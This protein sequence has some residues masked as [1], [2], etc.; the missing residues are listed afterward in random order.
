MDNKKL[1]LRKGCTIAVLVYIL[2]AA[3][4]LFI[5]RYQIKYTRDEAVTMAENATT[6]LGALQD[7]DVVTQHVKNG[8]QFLSS[9]Q[10]YFA[11]YGQKNQGQVTM[12]TTD[13][14]T[15]A[16]IF[17]KT[18]AL[19]GFADNAWHTFAADD[20]IDVSDSMDHEFE[21]TFTFALSEGDS[22]TMGCGNDL[23]G[24]RI[25]LLNG[26]QMVGN[27]CVTLN[28][29]NLSGKAFLYPVMLGVL[30]VLLIAGSI[31]IVSCDARDKK[32]VIVDFFYLCRRY[33]FLMDQLV[34]RD[35]KTKYKRSVL[36]VF[37]SFLNPLLTM[38]VQYVVF[39][40]LFR[41]NVPNYPMYLLTGIVF[42]NG[43]NDASTQAMNAIVGNASLIT[44]VYVPKYIYP[45]SKVLSA[46]INILFSLIPLF[47][48]ALI[49]GV[50]PSL[51]LLLIP[52][53]V[54]CYLLFIIGLSFILSSAMTFFRDMQF[55]WGVFTMMWMYAT[56]VIYP[57]STIEG[58]FLHPLQKI[59]PLYHFITFFR[60]VI[61]SGVSP[62]PT[63]YIICIGIAVIA[64]AVG[65]FVFRK[66]QDKFILYI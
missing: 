41:F 17:E 13:L 54:V 51:S 23:T 1:N 55:L 34:S 24:D 16:V 42:F 40:R 10:A 63:E 66:S 20:L 48:V 46:S 44:K 15:G 21:V 31:W 36:G 11:T 12:K 30:L 49:T 27:L 6:N 39:S 58:T 38:A 53:G 33:K 7:G 35:F 32:N 65:G 59:N 26:E 60:T 43:F 52:F 28:Q 29:T 4:F 9:V 3:F 50:R 56:P 5:A 14:D 37:W 57:L 45:I 8:H 25:V 61:I 22:V 18:E 19:A 2:C 62:E 64:L 47:L